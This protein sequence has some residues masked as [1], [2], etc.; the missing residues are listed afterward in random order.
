MRKLNWGL[1]LAVLFSVGTWVLIGLFIVWVTGC[2]LVI[3]DRVFLVD[4]LKNRDIDVVELVSDPNSITLKA[5]K[6]QSDPEKVG[7]YTGAGVFRGG[8]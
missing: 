4:I 7:I 5:K 3:T 8:D 2:T 6:W 1:I